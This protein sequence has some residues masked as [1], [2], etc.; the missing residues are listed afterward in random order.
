MGHPTVLEGIEFK[1]FVGLRRVFFG[2]GIRV[3]CHGAPPTSEC[4]AF[5]KESRMK[6]ANASKLDRKP[7]VRLGEPGAPVLSLCLSFSPPSLSPYASWKVRVG[8]IY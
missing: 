4:A 7:G 8:R 5:I 1:A 3:S 6:L 2:P